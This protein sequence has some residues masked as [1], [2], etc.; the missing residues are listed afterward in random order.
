[1]TQRTLIINT[2]ISLREQSQFSATDNYAIHL[3]RK[4]GIINLLTKSLS[5]VTIL[6]QTNFCDE[7]TENIMPYM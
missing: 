7:R 5:F 6:F 4:Y 2:K 1:M 3:R